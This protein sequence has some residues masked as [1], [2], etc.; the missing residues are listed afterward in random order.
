MTPAPFGAGRV[1]RAVPR[2]LREGEVFRSYWGAHTISLFGDQ[3]SLL[4]LPLVAVLALDADAAQMGYLTAFALAPNLLL[5]LHAGAWVDRHAHRRRAMIAADLGR[6]GVIATV[7]V[8][9]MLDV[10][11]LEQLFVVAFVAGALTVLFG[12]AD[13]SLFQTIVPRDRFV[14]ASALLNGSRAFS[15]VVGPTTAGFLVQAFTA[16][17]ALLLDAFSFLGSG[18]LLARIHPEEPPPDLEQK[19]VTVG[20]RW[21]AGSAVVRSTLA[22]TATINFFNFVFWALF[23][24]YATRTLGVSPGTLGLVLGAGAI[25]GLLGSVVAGPLARWIGVGPTLLAGC[26]LFPMPRTPRKRVGRDRARV[27]VPGGVRV[28]NRR[29]AARH[30]R[31]RDLRGDHSAQ[32]PLAGVRRLQLRQLRHQGAR[33]PRRWS[34]RKRDRRAADALD[35]RCR[36]APRGPDSAPVARTAAARPTRRARVGAER[37]G[38]APPPVGGQA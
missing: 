37:S 33:I 25:G 2:L 19:G 17:G 29:H 6:A 13:S 22:A 21:I 7:P 16:P 3:V 36:G 14:E 1:R 11:A 8:A 12:V 20:L 38:T 27:L 26:A 15:F 35:R 9:Y 4:A 23:I 10:L 5:A 32:A 31:G 34:A 28:G 24:L 18:A 30:Q